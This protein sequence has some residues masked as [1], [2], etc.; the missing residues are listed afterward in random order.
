VTK[1]YA[2]AGGGGD[3]LAA[4]IVHRALGHSEPAVIAT[5]AW[6]RLWID[7]LPG[8]RRPADF[9]GLRA[10]GQHN[11]AIGRDT[12]PAP[13]SRSTLPRLAGALQDYLVLL[14]P[15]GGARGMRAQLRELAEI[16]RPDA[17]AVLD[18]GGDVLARGDEVGLL[19]PLADAL[20]LAATAELDVEVDVVVAGP[21]LDGELTE[22]EV[23]AVVGDTPVGAVGADTIE[24]FRAILDW[25]PSEATA[26]LAAAARGA[27]GRVEIRDT[28]RQVVLSDRSAAIYRIGRRKAV[29]VNRLARSAEDTA[30]LLDVERA[31][32][33][34]GIVSELS[35]ERAKAQRTNAPSHHP[36]HD[37]HADLRA[38]DEAASARGADYLTFR[39]IS[40]GVGV[41]VDQSDALRHYLQAT[42]CTTHSWPL[43]PVLKPADTSS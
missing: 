34:L 37:L 6:D 36:P 15:H 24:Q 27:R 42:R 10:L 35:Y 21:A 18:V 33:A 4:A 1:L 3:A 26:L 12:E 32:E 40:E 39:R 38:I 17:I 11:Y 2:A 20:A 16:F 19:S 30:S 29:E 9:R 22:T 28:G 41:S 8:P 23:A 14:D 25:H 5:Y 31:A 7:P 43:W 13:P